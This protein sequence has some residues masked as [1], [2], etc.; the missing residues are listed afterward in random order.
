MPADRLPSYYRVLSR[1]VE[2]VVDGDA[3]ASDPGEG[4]GVHPL[5][6]QPSREAREWLDGQIED[7]EWIEAIEEVDAE[8]DAMDELLD[9]SNQTVP[10]LL[11]GAIVLGP[12]QE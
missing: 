9:F 12:H 2:P 1:S 8:D 7:I 10:Q 4:E 5:K 3:T 6:R 11:P